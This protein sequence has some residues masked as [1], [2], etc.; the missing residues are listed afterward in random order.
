MTRY[1][2]RVIDDRRLEL[3]QEALRIIRPGQEI[4]IDLEDSPE[5]QP[6]YTDRLIREAPTGTTYGLERT[7]D[8]QTA[9]SRV[10]EFDS[11]AEQ[12]RRETGALSD[13]EKGRCI[14]L[15][16]GSSVWART[17]FL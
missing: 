3:P 13:T 14:P 6:S 17:L 10:D 9:T 11:L 15:I 2:A 8:V 5:T 1:T 12:W 16:S 4:E 7:S